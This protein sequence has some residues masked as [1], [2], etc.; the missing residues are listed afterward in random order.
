MC[1]K[2]N[3]LDKMVSAIFLFT[4]PLKGLERLAKV[5]P[6]STKGY[7]RQLVVIRQ[8]YDKQVSSYLDKLSESLDEVKDLMF[9]HL[10]YDRTKDDLATELRKTHISDKVKTIITLIDK[11]V[12]QVNM[13]MRN[14]E[15]AV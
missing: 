6:A 3:L 13:N 9:S 12:F 5:L 7:R 11:E 15:E 4:S 14:T 2:S 8:Q 10:T 1:T